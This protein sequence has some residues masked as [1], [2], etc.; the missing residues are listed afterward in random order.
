MAKVARAESAFC[1]VT[2]GPYVCIHRQVGVSPSG[3][4][5]LAA[6]VTT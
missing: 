5:K 2:G 6:R 1:K 3:S 4:V